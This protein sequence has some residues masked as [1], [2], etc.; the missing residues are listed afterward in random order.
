MTEDPQAL[1]P[2]QSFE[3][4]PETQPV[5]RRAVF[6]V[7]VLQITAHHVD[8]AGFASSGSQPTRR[9]LNDASLRLIDDLTNRPVDPLFSDARLVTR[10]QS[11]VT[12]WLTRIVV[13]LICITVGF[14]GSLVV[15]QLQSDPRKEVRESL[16]AEL[17]QQ[18]AT[19]DELSQ[20]VIDLRKQVDHESEI[21]N[22][23]TEDA[24]NIQDEMAN[25]FVEVRGEGITLSLANPIAAGGDN[26]DDLF[27]DD[28]GS[29]IQVVTDADL[30]VFLSL[31]WQAGA[32]AI[33]INGN[34]IG[35]Q[36]SVRSA[37][38]IIL[39]GVHQIQSPYT[40][41]AI[42]SSREMAAALNSEHLPDLYESFNDAGIYPHI[43][44]SH[45]ITLEAADS[46]DVTHARVGKN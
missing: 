29:S 37:G 42:G 24:I 11:P 36:T 33:A 2:P 7:S 8:P 14:A 10:K 9:T 3:V 22:R 19:A 43:T 4:S 35:V 23:D 6:S 25:G 39:V 18:T 12:L 40:I 16:A 31:L 20:E 21:L 5:R 26:A 13:F 41:Q 30:Q 44:Q 17:R 1:E 27:S 34:R 38:G 45:T 46:V 28:V 15:R 32:E